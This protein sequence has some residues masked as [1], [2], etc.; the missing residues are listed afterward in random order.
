MSDDNDAIDWDELSSIEDEV[1]EEYANNPAYYGQRGSAFNPEFD[2]SDL[3]SDCEDLM[4]VAL[5]LNETNS[6]V[7][8]L[9]QLGWESEYPIQN[10]II[11]FYW[12]G[13]GD[14]PPECSSWV[15]KDGVMLNAAGEVLEIDLDID[16]DDE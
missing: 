9:K 1:L 14:P 7:I 16:E 11:K 12:A 13:E 15:E 4:E 3:L 2:L 5:E 10:A 8:A 6:L